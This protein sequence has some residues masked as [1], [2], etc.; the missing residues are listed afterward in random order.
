MN[1]VTTATLWP[2]PLDDPYPTLAVLRAE[3]H[4]QYL[5]GLDC[6]LVIAHQEANAVLSGPGW[7][8]DP[9]T[10][11]ATAERLALT[12]GGGDLLA[13]SVL[14]SDPPDHQRLRRALGG[15]FA[16]RAVERLRPRIRSIVEA[17]FSGLNHSEDFDVMAELAHAVPLAVICELLDAGVDMARVLKRETPKMTALLDPLAGSDALGDGAAAGFGVMLEL[18]PLVA[19]RRTQPGDD[20]LSALVSTT[21]EGEPGLEPDEAI[22]M[23][24]LLLTAG[25]ETTANLI[26]NAVVCLCQHPDQTR[27]LRQ[28]PERLGAA[29]EELLRFESPVQL[30]ARVAKEPVELDGVEIE[31][32][33]QVLVC[34]GG[35]N[36]DPS[37]FLDPDVL[38]FSRDGSGHLAFGHGAHFCAGASL[39]RVEAQ[40]V[41]AHLMS[42]EP[43]L[44]DREVLVHRGGSRTFRRIEELQLRLR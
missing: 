23:A 15:H 33:T 39:A 16:P 31:A 26:G 44:E 6:H 8:A 30:T 21:A 29:I 19:E 5:A 22:M 4:V 7:S 42:L 3:H 12:D 18:L 36:R 37:A 14:F 43:R 9:R 27:W 41:L 11:P 35:A 24:L 13:K 2:I 34:V 32:G 25:H 17:A 20:L 40:E 38:D 1:E 10:N 28:H